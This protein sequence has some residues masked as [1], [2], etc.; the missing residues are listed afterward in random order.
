MLERLRNAIGDLLVRSGERI[1]AAEPFERP[2]GD[3]KRF[4]DRTFRDA[5]RYEGFRQEYENGPAADLRKEAV[6]AI[7]HGEQGVSPGLVDAHHGLLLYAVTREL[8]PDCVVETGVC[9]GFSSLAILLALDENE[10]GRLISIDLPFRADESLESFR[11]NTF[12]GYGGASIPPDEE[13]GWV[14]PDDLRDRWR[15]HLG[16]SQKKLPEVV[17]DEPAIDI[18][19]HDSEHSEPCMMFEYE[20]AWE[21]LTDGGLLLSDDVDWNSAFEEFVTVRGADH[22]RVGQEFGYAIKGGPGKR[23]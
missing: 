8:R 18:F 11:E 13:P 16:K 10:R 3:L 17:N 2:T 19:V 14:V 7:D 21:R 6:E 23:G 4:I 1:R 20:L 9:N 15:L 12:Q 22:G 5:E